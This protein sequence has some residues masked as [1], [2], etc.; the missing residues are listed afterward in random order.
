LVLGTATATVRPGARRKI[1]IVFTPAGRRAL[2][3]RR[4]L[5]IRLRVQ[6][7]YNGHIASFTI[8]DTIAAP[9]S[10]KHSGQRH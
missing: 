10:T 7:T 9:R 1:K 4:A 5:R 2:K 3:A 6:L 8:A